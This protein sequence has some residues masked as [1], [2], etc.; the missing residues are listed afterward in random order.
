MSEAKTTKQFIKAN[1]ESYANRLL[2][3]NLWLVSKN[4]LLIRFFVIDFI[5]LLD[6]HDLDCHENPADF[7]AMTR[8]WRF[9]WIA[10][11]RVANL[12]M[13]KNIESHNDDNSQF[14]TILHIYTL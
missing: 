3:A 12:A 8:W 14:F 11:I 7:L 5:Y 13:M 9:V 4:N 6:S 10:L 2:W 1:R